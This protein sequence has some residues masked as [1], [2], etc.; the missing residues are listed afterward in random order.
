NADAADAAGSGLGRAAASQGRGRALRHRARHRG[1]GRLSANRVDD[2]AEQ[3]GRCPREILLL[4]QLA[5]CPC[6]IRHPALNSLLLKTLP[7]DWSDLKLRAGREP[8]LGRYPV[9]AAAG[10]F[11]FDSPIDASASGAPGPAFAAERPRTKSP[12]SI[13]A[14]LATRK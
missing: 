13:G 9:E 12:P 2:R 8:V 7:L 6:P 14:M 5:R 3:L 10:R 11:L 4:R 1:A